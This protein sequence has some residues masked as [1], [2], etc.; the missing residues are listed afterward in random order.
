MNEQPKAETI[1][2][3]GNGKYEACGWITYGKGSVLEGQSQ[4]CVVGIFQSLEEAKAKYPSAEVSEYGRCKEHRPTVPL[5][6]PSDF[7]HY[8]AGEYW[9]ENDY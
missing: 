7:D 2:P 6:A 1:Y 3:F 4:E 5:N 9:G 8:D